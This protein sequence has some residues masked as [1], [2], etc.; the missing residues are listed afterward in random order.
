MKLLLDTNVIIDYCCHR[1]SFYEVS[2]EIFRRAFA[3]EYEVLVTP[4]TLVNFFYI[5]RKAYTVEERYDILNDL[6]TICRVAT[7]DEDVVHDAVSSHS[8]DFEDMVQLHSAV[9]AHLDA[10]ITRN[11]QDFSSSAIPV[12]TPSDFLASL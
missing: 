3:G 6:L 4:T 7:T 1:P 11:V 5:T 9:H 8:R 2:A 10:I 12:L